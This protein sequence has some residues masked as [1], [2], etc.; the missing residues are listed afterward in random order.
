MTISNPIS[1]GSFPVLSDFNQVNFE[2]I[3]HLGLMNR[4]ETKFAFPSYKIDQVLKTLTGDYQVFQRN[5]HISFKYVTVYLDT[6]EYSFFNQHLRGELSRNKVRYRKYEYTGDSFLEI[7]KKT[8]KGRT[9]KW[10][11]PGVFSNSHFKVDAKDFLKEHLP[12]EYLLLK[13][14]LISRFSR[15]TF[16]NMDLRERLTIDYDLSFESVISGKFIKLP[17]L[18]IAEVKR[19]NQNYSSPF[20]SALRRMNI[21]PASFSK[22]CMGIALLNDSL[23]INT[24]KPKL[25]LL[26][27]IENG[28]N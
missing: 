27:K 20:T 3:S 21:H 15:A 23:K 10:R 24:L 28:F 16:I 13:P 25:L 2:S 22:Y 14:V 6:E 18:S 19:E 4:V 8:N 26:K 17:Y 12:I 5:N 11:I 7:K 9:L 1:Y